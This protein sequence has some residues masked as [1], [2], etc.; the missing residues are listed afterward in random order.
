[1]ND[2][3]ELTTFTGWAATAAGA[4]LEPFSY[5]PG[6]LGSDEVEVAVEYCGVCHSDQSLID[7]DWGISSYPFIPGHEVVGRIVRVGDQVRGL[8]MGQRVGIG[9]YKGSCMHCT[10]CIEGSH[11]LCRTVQPTIIGSNGGFADRI[12]SHWAWALPIP[13]G[14]D[15]AM[16]GPLF[17]AGSTVFNPLVVFGIKPTD[18]VGVVGIGG[19][20]HLAL[21]FLNAWGCEVTAFTSSLSK[22]DEA[23]RLGAHKVVASTDTDALNAIAG[24]LDFLL[25]TANANLDWTAMLATL[26]GKGRL[27]FVGVVPDA[28][29]VHVFNLIPQQKVLSA[30]PVGSPANTAM[31]LEFCARHQIL[32]QVEMFPMSRINEAIDHLR[33]GKARYRV[34]LD[35]SQ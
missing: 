15:P 10:S 3:S 29:P 11:N 22:Q 33:S 8:E 7:N 31:M 13:A 28:I 19:L 25:V 9:W 24:T 23:R 2:S 26:R 14:L 32:P 6:P 16:A 21:R 4:P 20:G 34:V 35:A 12:R 27:H 17:C 1:M 18:R 5:D 30:S